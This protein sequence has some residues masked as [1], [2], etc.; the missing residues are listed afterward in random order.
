ML[1]WLKTCALYLRDRLHEH[2]T[3]LAIGGAIGT[4]ALF[5]APDKW[6]ALAFLVAAALVPN[7]SFKQ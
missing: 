4:V 2:G 1:A 3:L 5:P 6:F 7:G